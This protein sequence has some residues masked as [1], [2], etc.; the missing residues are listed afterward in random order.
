MLIWACFFFKVVTL[1]SDLVTSLWSFT[2]ICGAATIG[3]GYQKALLNILIIP[4]VT[5]DEKMQCKRALSWFFFYIHYHFSQWLWKWFSCNENKRAFYNHSFTVFVSTAVKAIHCTLV[6]HITPRLF[7]FVETQSKSLWFSS[8]HI[9]VAVSWLMR[10]CRWICEKP[11]ALLPESGSEQ[12]ENQCWPLQSCMYFSMC[13][14]V[15]ITQHCII[16]ETT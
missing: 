11:S 16:S 4:C 1:R 8:M 3:L 12:Q 6:K 15:I 5:W 13:P 9:S 14:L 2:V 10:S 7:V